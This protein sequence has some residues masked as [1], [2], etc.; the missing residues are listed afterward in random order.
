MTGA[1]AALLTLSWPAAVAAQLTPT[2][3]GKPATPTEQS[4]R[5]GV[6]I[7]DSWST[8]DN[9]LLVPHPVTLDGRVLLD[10]GIRYYQKWGGLGDPTGAKNTLSAYLILAALNQNPVLLETSPADYVLRFLPESEQQKYVCDQTEGS[11]DYPGMH[12]QDQYHNVRFWAGAD[13]TAKRQTKQDFLKDY[14]D[15]FLAAAPKLPIDLVDV[16]YLEQSILYDDRRDA[17][18]VA[19]RLPGVH[20]IEGVTHGNVAFYYQKN[21]ESD[22][23]NEWLA[24]GTAAYGAVGPYISELWFVDEAEGQ[25][26]INGF[27]K[28]GLFSL[29]VRHDLSLVELISEFGTM[30]LQA[31][32]HFSTALYEDQ[33]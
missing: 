7:P 22:P 2:Q 31:N 4:T 16:S 6:H 9:G 28:L 11:C 17:F 3:T 14:R 21:I 32:L 25:R 20:S 19:Y 13:E 24:P 30:G 10:G 5:S 18:P 23:D 12:N 1:T 15:R 27:R 8:L 26:K 33:F 29:P